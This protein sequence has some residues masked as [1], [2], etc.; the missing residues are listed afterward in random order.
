MT[1]FILRRLA[2]SALVLLGLSV[3]TFALARVVPSNPA[4]IYIGPKARPEDIARVTQEL[5]LDR[6][7]RRA[8][9]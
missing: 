2:G 6:R 3:I 4:A 1:R 8:R 5:G 9:A 7:A